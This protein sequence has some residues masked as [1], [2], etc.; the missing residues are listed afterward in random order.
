MSL[1]TR[2]KILEKIGSGSFATV[3]R[4]KDNEL[5]REVAIK[6][7]HSEFLAD[8]GRLD[9][10]WQEAQLLASLQH[11]N[12]VTIF[13]IVR[14]RGWLVMELMQSSLATR[15]AGRQVDLRALRASLAHC[16]R[17][18]KYLHAQGII[19][20]D[21]KPANL[22]ID[23]RRRVKLGDFGL[24]RRVA[25]AEGSLL[26]GTTKYMAPE[27]VSDD[28]GDV[29]P[30]SDL[31][32]LGFTAYDLMCGEN[33]DEL[34][35]GLN[36]KGRNQQLAWM[37]WHAAPDRVLP[38]IDRVLEGVPPDVAKVV[39]KLTQKDPALRYKTADEA[40]S[41]LQIDLKMIGTQGGGEADEPAPDEGRRRRLIAIGALGASV[42]MSAA[43]L[44]MGGGNTGKQT[45]HK[46][47]GLIREVIADQNEF[48]VQD[49]ETGALEPFKVP[50]KQRIFLLNTKN[51]I[52]LKELLPGDHVELD[53]DKHQPDLAVNVIVDRPVP[54]RGTL[55][56][57]NLTDSRIVLG[58]EEG[59]TRD[60][61]PVRIP[62]TAKLKLNGQD[63]KLRD[64]Q[65]GDRLE[66]THLTEPGAAKG[67]VLNSLLAR[68]TTTTVGF[69]SQFD[70]AS[71]LL[72]IQIGQGASAGSVTLPVAK[73]CAVKLN[74][75]ERQA[76]A[77]GQAEQPVTV[78]SLKPGDR[79]SLTHD[80]DVVEIT[81]TRNLQF[82][83]TLHSVSSDSSA[84]TLV[85]ATG[86]RKQLS[87]DRSC[88][89]TL[90]VERVQL[91]DLRQFDNV[92]ATYVEE[93]DGNLK[94][95]TI[96]ARR[97]SQADRW[98]VVIGTQGYSDATL[99]PLTTALNDA[100]LVQ[101]MLVSRYAVSEQRAA[102]LIDAKKLEWER[103][104]SETLASAR[105]QTQVLIC[106]IGHAYVGD[107]G[108]VYLA[109]KDFDFANMPTTGIALDWL[110]EKLNECSSKDKLLVLDVTPAVSGKDAKRQRAG[111]ELLDKLK[112]PI[113]ST[114]VLVSCETGEQSRVWTEK[115]H[116]LFAWWLAE[117]LQ[118]AADTD[119]DL[120]LT[121]DELFGYLL[122][123]S[124]TAKAR[125]FADQTPVMVAPMP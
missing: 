16:L 86:E 65:L 26:K 21:I 5:G 91:L 121:P 83:G 30:Q 42:L 11:P 46:S 27:T 73:K 113:Q 19:H 47:H 62:E 58:M 118:G 9:R 116:G 108:R 85:L 98:T 67:R 71:S 78:A 51:N 23:I 123:Q 125:V 52:Q 34:F 110:A 50:R 6:Q 124:A 79:V 122:N 84:L 107:D 13:D 31:Y 43:M 1:D 8:A 60:D 45:V 92:R 53:V 88:E 22:M 117:G 48:V 18:L 38:D 81:A 103:Q 111:N 44:F 115:Q 97:P 29:G 74:G 28:F 112:M 99:S 54:T 61:L 14:E 10:F 87:V 72:T 105:P 56:T 24:A 64:L 114:H 102:L 69:V 101:G 76:G 66:I 82:E 12:I 41:D 104:L 4:A 106:V 68:R 55:K 57:M 49:L 90:A 33:F 2:Y 25:N 95:V 63:I 119:R 40:L 96:D 20:G 35:P 36:A 109:P 15:L 94:G 89:I 37:M 93:A 120:H 75:S 77:S 39:Q 100:R 59:N 32:S 7:L 80:T 17:A 70:A 3:Y